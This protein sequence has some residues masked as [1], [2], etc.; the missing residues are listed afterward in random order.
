M[1]FLANNVFENIGNF[2]GKMGS[3][4]Q[5]I[6]WTIFA[7]TVI[8]CGVAWVIGGRGAEFAKSTLGRVVVAVGVVAMATAII[9]TLAQMYGGGGA[10]TSFKGGLKTMVEPLKVYLWSKGIFF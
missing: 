7:V 4:I 1:L 2:A 9:S 5:G 8:I 6:A 3:S 10:K